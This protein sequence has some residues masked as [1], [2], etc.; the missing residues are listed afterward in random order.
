MLWT[1]KIGTGKLGGSPPKISPRASGPPVEATIPIRRGVPGC[2]DGWS[3]SFLLIFPGICK[4]S[5]L[6]HP[7]HVPPSF[8]ANYGSSF[9]AQVGLEVVGISVPPPL[10]LRGS[11]VRTTRHYPASA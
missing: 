1:T 6:D 4:P 3:I 2:R 10:E 11:R 8:R 9:T 5:L 7:L